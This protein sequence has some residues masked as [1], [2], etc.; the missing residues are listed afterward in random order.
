MPKTTP[1]GLMFQTKSTSKTDRLIKSLIDKY[2]ISEKS[3]RWSFFKILMGAMAILLWIT[4]YQQHQTNTLIWGGV[5][6][7]ILLSGAAAFFTKSFSC[8]M[9][10]TVA[11]SYLLVLSISASIASNWTLGAPIEIGLIWAACTVL[12]MLKSDTLYEEQPTKAAIA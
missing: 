8:F 6:V 10:C 11:W 2:G 7:T 3:F 1:R 4:H 5:I 12:V 9:F